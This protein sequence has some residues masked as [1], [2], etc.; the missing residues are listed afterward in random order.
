MF[1]FHRN[2]IEI[3]TQAV[4]LLHFLDGAHFAKLVLSLANG[5]DKC[6][7]PCKSGACTASST[8]SLAR[9]ALQLSKCLFAVELGL[10]RMKH[11]S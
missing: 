6:P 1:H 5:H 4:F 3:N 7:M 10:L 9:L 8:S 11:A 2:Q